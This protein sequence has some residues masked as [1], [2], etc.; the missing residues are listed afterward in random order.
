MFTYRR[1]VPKMPYGF[2]GRKAPC[3]LTGDRSLKS[4]LVSVDV[5]VP[6][7]LTGYR[8]LKSLTVSVDVKVPCLL[9]G[10]RPL[11]SLTVSGDVKHHVY[12]PETGP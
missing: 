5:K 3:L 4:L 7:L 9:T 11:K 2:C 12:L 1:P 8:P 6:C 10:Y